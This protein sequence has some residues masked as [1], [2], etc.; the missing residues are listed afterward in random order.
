MQS[1]MC[2]RSS[3][4]LRSTPQAGQGIRIAGRPAPRRHRRGRMLAP[5]SGG[6]PTRGAQ[7]STQADARPR[8]ATIERRGWRPSRPGPTP[9]RCRARDRSPELPRR[10][11]NPVAER[12]REPKLVIRRIGPWWRQHRRRSNPGRRGAPKRRPERQ[13]EPIWNGGRIWRDRH[14]EALHPDNHRLVP[15]RPKQRQS[16][17]ADRKSQL[18]PLRKIGHVEYFRAVAWRRTQCRRGKPAH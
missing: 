8:A 16:S 18:F 1:E 7:G 4:A 11:W 17:N 12:P 13:F 3:R 10:A 9:S 2:A 15:Q 5:F 6:H 14:P